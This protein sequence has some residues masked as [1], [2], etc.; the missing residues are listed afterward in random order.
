VNKYVS[1]RDTATIAA[2]KYGGLVLNDSV[3][4]L[5]TTYNFSA[6][7]KPNVKYYWRVRGW[8][9]AGSSTFSAVDSFTIMFLPA[10]PTLANPAHN[11]ANVPVPVTFQWNRVAGDSNY[12]VQVWTYTFS[13]L[14]QTFDTVGSVGSLVKSGLLNRQK[15]YW[16]VQALNQGGVG[17]FT[18]PDSFTTV[19]ELAAAPLTVGPKS[20]TVTGRKMTFVWNSSLNATSYH[21]QVAAQNFPTAVLSE[22]VKV[23]DTTYTIKDTLLASTTYYWQVSAINLGGEGAFSSTAHFATGT[24]VSVETPTAN[25]PKEFALMQNFPNPFNPTTTIN[26]DVP[27]TSVVTLKI[28]DVLGRVVA[29]L[30]DGVQEASSYRIQWNASNMASGVYFYRISARSQDGSTNFTSVRKLVLMK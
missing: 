14:T 8:N 22:D 25:I 9:A 16:K 21:L 19:I 3:N 29:T 20:P 13:G 4:V 10:T 11:A 23:T 12:V 26:Y 30:V 2:N 24:T 6:S 27:K 15:Y 17:S 7:L 28:Y 18:A 1:V 5:D